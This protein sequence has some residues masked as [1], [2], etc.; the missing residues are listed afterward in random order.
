MGIGTWRTFDVRGPGEEAIR[1]ALVSEALAAGDPPWFGPA[2]R[3]RV[4][5]LAHRYSR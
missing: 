1:T 2:E 3:E 4:S 5:A